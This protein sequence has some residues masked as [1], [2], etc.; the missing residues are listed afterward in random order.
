M[1]IVVKGVILKNSIILHLLAFYY[2]QKC[3]LTYFVIYLLLFVQTHFFYSNRLEYIKIIT[4]VS[5]QIV[6]ELANGS[7]FK[8]GPGSFGYTPLFLRTFLFSS[9]EKENS[10]LFCTFPALT[11]ESVLSPKRPGSI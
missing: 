3:S 9:T 6:P 8:W 4:Y 2:K 5:T 11:L 10:G 1:M 7:F